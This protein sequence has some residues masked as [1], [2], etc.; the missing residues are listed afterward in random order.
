MPPHLRKCTDPSARKA[1][2]LVV[3][4]LFLVFAGLAWREE[5]VSARTQAS[6]QAE[7]A[8]DPGS[9]RLLLENMIR[10]AH[11]DDRAKLAASIKDT[12]IRN[13]TEWFKATFGQE[14]GEGW[15]DSYR[16]GLEERE[17]D[18]ADMLNGFSRVSGAISVQKLDPKKI[19]DS[20][21][22]PLDLYL[23]DWVPTG[24]NGSPRP[25]HIGYF[26]FVEGRFSWD[27]TVIFARPSTTAD[28]E[29]STRT[30]SQNAHGSLPSRTNAA[31]V[32]FPACTYCPAPEYS[33]EG[34]QAKFNGTVVMRVIIQA[35]GTAINIEVVKSSNIPSLDEKAVETL[36]QWRFKP[37]MDRDGNPVP[38]ATSVEVTFHLK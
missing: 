18:L 31:V 19:Y 23:A 20:L 21:R 6:A 26:Y 3:A 22:R 13:Y 34:R 38:Y 14:K 28:S 17:R 2:S 11:S 27:S 7:N 24:A 37:A 10:M 33:K 5:N 1:T 15:A 35:D 9:L 4:G 29:N 25:Q 8:N 12:E 36:R 32:T 16:A 30:A